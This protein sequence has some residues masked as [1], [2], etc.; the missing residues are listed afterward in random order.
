MNHQP[1][2][3]HERYSSLDRKHG[4]SASIQL[5]TCVFILQSN[6]WPHECPVLSVVD[7][8]EAESVAG[9]LV[10]VALT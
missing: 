2:Q 9:W 6:A 8:T 7:M 10:D 1:I 5:A 3:I 4:S